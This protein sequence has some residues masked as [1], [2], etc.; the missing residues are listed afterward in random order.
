MT[1]D[2]YNEGLKFN[3]LQEDWRRLQRHPNTD[4]DHFALY[5]NHQGSSARPWVMVVQRLWKNS[6]E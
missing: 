3:A 6:L 1:V 5:L 4:L 2:V